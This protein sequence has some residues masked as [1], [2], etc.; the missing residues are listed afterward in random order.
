[1]KKLNKLILLITTICSLDGSAQTI[2][3]YVPTSNLLAWYSFNSN[4]NDLS[5]N[6]NNGTVNGAT[7]STDRFGIPNSA[8]AFNGSNSYIDLAASIFNIP[9]IYSISC[10]SKFN[11][12]SFS[13]LFG[14]ATNGEIQ[15]QS[16]GSGNV[17]SW[18]KLN[19][20]G[21]VS[22]GTII[23]DL[24]NWHHLVS[25]FNNVTK[26]LTLYIDN[27]GYSTTI[28]AGVNIATFTGRALLGRQSNL[29]ANFFNGKL[30]DIGF[31]NRELTPCEIKK[32]YY[33][34]AFNIASSS[35][36]ICAG[37]TA[38]LTAT[39]SPNYNWSSAET[40]SSIIV[41]PTVTTIYTVS[42]TYTSSCTESKTISVVVQSQPSI[43]V[44]SGSI[45]QGSSFTIVPS[46][47]I[48]YTYSSGTGI[49]SPT[50]NTTYTVIGTNAVG[51]TNTAISSVIVNTI[52]TI[53]VNSGTICSGNSFSFTPSGAN[54]YTYSS[55]S[56][57]VSPTVNTNYSV[58]GTSSLGCVSSN[59]AV[60][61]VTV[62]TLP[63]VSVTSGAI[64]AGGS[65][66]MTAS[67]ANTYT[68]SGGSAVVNPTANTS[69]SITGTSSLG[70][71]SS[72]TAIA[73]VTV[74]ALPTVSV[75]SGAICAG[76]SYSMTPSG[77]NTYTYSG[78]SA[79][80]SPTANT[81]YS[82]T[83]TSSFGC[84]S[85]NTAVATVTVNALP[86]ITANSGTI[87]SGN[88][89]TISASGASTYTYSSGSVVS[90]T[91]TETYTV[92]G[93][94]TLGCIGSAVS[95][96]T[97]NANP[98]VT[99][100]TSNSLICV[101][102]SA[103]LTASTTATSYAW[104][105]GATTMSVSVSPTVTSTYTVNVSNTA[106]CIASS[107]VM[108]TVDDCSGINEVIAN[109]I[110]IYPNPNNGLFSIE[111]KETTQVI[112]TNILG[113]ILLNST[114]HAGKQILDIKNNANGIYFVQLIK[115]GKQQT[116]KLI[117]E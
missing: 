41:S 33:Y 49:I 114:L 91:A 109:S 50:T 79:V 30:D 100:S 97:V 57:V 108:V 83:G 7:L 23:P 105:T 20:G 71:V 112:I 68:Y 10:W 88:S 11:S 107:T 54:T 92:T 69:Y 32:L 17:V 98:T 86:T 95:S 70:C 106:A 73:T 115:E 93:T 77:A 61:T 53:S 58:T 85:S 27:I 110:S 39:G 6:G 63:T 60:A 12:T 116:I 104:N 43:T 67:G 48:S 15:L 45:C 102:N 1:M 74:N 52:P 42:S 8:Y 24:T 22:V 4:A 31:W 75:T 55:G 80:V 40:T 81:S 94:S 96:I 51:C 78:G 72:N 101:G 99:A 90:P 56:A 66:S 19:S 34:P 3:S 36:S 2:P 14:Q 29:A 35:Y 76:G 82:I 38:T 89:F 65:Y 103:I 113:H 18:N 111:L 59:T 62:N 21:S 47:A 28:P 44:N 13:Y 87:C 84:V 117:K 26:T 37:Q 25:I 5:G 9:Q 16:D 46:G 64:C